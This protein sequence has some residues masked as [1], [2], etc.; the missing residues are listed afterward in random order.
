MGNTTLKNDAP[1]G[2][3]GI[4]IRGSGL[5]D[6]AS[7]GGTAVAG[8]C[9]YTQV[10]RKTH[11][12][13][14]ADPGPAQT[15][16]LPGLNMKNRSHILQNICLPLLRPSQN[17]PTWQFSVYCRLA[18]HWASSA[19]TSPMFRVVVSDWDTEVF[20]V[21]HAAVGQNCGNLNRDCPGKSNQRRKPAACWSNLDPYPY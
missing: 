7:R 1:S 12:G 5:V 19:W 15:T 3:I 9:R 18:C 6:G 11:A 20:W 8:V 13:D 4:V 2:R 14:V 16:F 21:S 17:L 10:T